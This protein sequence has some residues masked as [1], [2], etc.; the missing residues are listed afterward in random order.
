MLEKLRP[1][2]RKTKKTV[3]TEEQVVEELL[4]MHH[5]AL[6]RI[7]TCL[8]FCNQEDEVELICEIIPEFERKKLERMN[9]AV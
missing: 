7:K 4:L 8:K 6:L 3:M 2:D 5:M 9:E 1:A